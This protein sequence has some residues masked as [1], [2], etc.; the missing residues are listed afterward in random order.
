M[1]RLKDVDMDTTN[2]SENDKSL[3][4][5]IMNQ[6]RKM[7]GD[8]GEKSNGITVAIIGGSGCGKSTLLTKVFIDKVFNSK[9]FIVTIFTDSAKSDAFSDINSK[10]ITVCKRGYDPDF[11]K[12]CYNVNLKYDKKYNFVNILDDCIDFKNDM[13]VRSMFCTMRNMNITSICSLQYTKMIPPAIRTSV[14]FTFIFKPNSNEG[15]EFVVSAYLR[16]YLAGKN[17]REKC[18]TFR[19]WVLGGE[20]K[21]K[22]HRFYLLD[23]LNNVGFKVDE[24]YNCEE[25]PVV[26]SLLA[27]QQQQSDV[28]KND[29]ESDNDNYNDNL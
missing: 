2:T 18:E 10:Q 1:E 13:D 29:S 15:Y 16:G 9:K 28:L 7:Q 11:I 24:N 21:A 25:M 14:Y 20:G 3:G 23:N 8:E 4:T 26:S 22:G 27:S 6:K 12:W 19:E 5:L 17:I